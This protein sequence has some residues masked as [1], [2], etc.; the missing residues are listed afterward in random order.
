MIERIRVAQKHVDPDP[1]H[2]LPGT[3]LN[4]FFL[5]FYSTVFMIHPHKIFFSGVVLPALSKSYA[6]G[7]LQKFSEG[8]VPGGEIEPGIGVQ[9]S[10][11]LSTK[12]RRLQYLSGLRIRIRTWLPPPPP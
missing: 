5:L 10:S 7:F 9:Q 6:R 1:E 8:G 3:L 11:A 4:Y 2:C 12:P